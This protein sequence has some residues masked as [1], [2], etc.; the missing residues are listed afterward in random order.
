MRTMQA[1]ALAT[2][3]GD[4]VRERQ[5]HRRFGHLLAHGREWFHPEPDLIAYI[6]ELRAASGIPP[7]DSAAPPMDERVEMQVYLAETTEN[8][9]IRTLTQDGEVLGGHMRMVKLARSNRRPQVHA[10]V[11]GAGPTGRTAVAACTQSKEIG[12]GGGLVAASTVPRQA[13][14]T[15]P[16][17]RVRWETMTNRREHWA[18]GS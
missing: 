16:A 5:L 6:N 2:E 4:I 3:P 12:H 14:C 11:T 17:C 13:R 7:L 8:P 10:A 1:R 18:H 9:I 15:R